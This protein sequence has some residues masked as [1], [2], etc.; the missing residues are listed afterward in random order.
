MHGCIHTHLI[1]T[2]LAHVKAHRLRDKV[3]RVLGRR[4]EADAT[5][6]GNSRKHNRPFNTDE[7]ANRKLE[8]R[9]RLWCGFFFPVR[10]MLFDARCSAVLT[11]VFPVSW[12]QLI[13]AKHKKEMTYQQI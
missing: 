4:T 10:L 5:G 3:C 6:L 8:R 11:L 2:Y 1:Y 9:M 13:K 12:E 7:T